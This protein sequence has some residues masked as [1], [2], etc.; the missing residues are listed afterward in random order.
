MRESSNQSGDERDDIL[1]FVNG[2][3]VLFS[4][5]EEKTTPEKISGNKKACSTPTNTEISISDLTLDASCITNV[6]LVVRLV[7]RI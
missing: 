7:F 1:S 5:V 6:K 4:V 2:V 3:N